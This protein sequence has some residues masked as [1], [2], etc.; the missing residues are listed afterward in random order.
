MSSYTE[1][2]TSFSIRQIQKIIWIPI[3]VLISI[4]LS[5]IFFINVGHE[6]TT[7]SLVLSELYLLI[8][9]QDS[10]ITNELFLGQQEAL[11]KRLYFLSKQIHSVDENV[12]VCLSLRQYPG[13]EKSTCPHDPRYKYIPLH[14]FNIGNKKIADLSY[15][16]DSLQKYSPDIMKDIIGALLSALLISAFMIVYLGKLIETKIV[17]PLIKHIESQSTDCSVAQIA[18]MLAHD[19]LKPFKT[20][21]MSL[22]QIEKTKSLNTPLLKETTRVV[23]QQ[24]DQVQA[25]ISDMFLAQDNQ[26]LALGFLT[27]REVGSLIDSSYEVQFRHTSCIWA[28]PY[29][30][31]RVFQNLIENAEKAM[32]PIGKIWIRVWQKILYPHLQKVRVPSPIP[33]ARRTISVPC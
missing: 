1:S 3:F 28:D 8:K 21:K 17:R 31:T 12:H 26:K 23:R 6:R 4:F 14:S 30:L 16:M 25:M 10:L 11:N 32:V 13:P 33:R 24:I 9:S 20:L 29:K 19:V 2:K 7:Q 15:A 27:P 18:T 22:S 5:M